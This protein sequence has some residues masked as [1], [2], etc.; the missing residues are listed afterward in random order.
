MLFTLSGQIS[1]NGKFFLEELDKLGRKRNIRWEGT[2]RENKL[3][4]IWNN[5]QERKKY[6][7][8]LTGYT[9]PRPPDRLDSLRQATKEEFGVDIPRYRL[10]FDYLGF[11]VGAPCYY[12]NLLDTSSVVV[13][14]FPAIHQDTTYLYLRPEPYRMLRRMQRVI[15]SPM[16]LGVSDAFRSSSTQ[17]L[18]YQKYGKTRLEAPGYSEHHLGTAVDFNKITKSSPEFLWLLEHAFDY[19]WVPSNYFREQTY[20]IPQPEHWRY[21]GKATALAFREAWRVEI[22]QLIRQLKS[23]KD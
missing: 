13:I 14:P 22:E 1:S 7:F 12:E 8:S 10:F 19:G 2:R 20:R 4:G 23:E 21:V 18:L 6:Y 16:V 17:S 15:E 11:P 9:P 5:T 3:K